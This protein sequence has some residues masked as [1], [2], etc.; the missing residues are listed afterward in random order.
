[1]LRAR[2]IRRESNFDS[3][4]EARNTAAPFQRKVPP[5]R[6]TDFAVSERFPR[7]SCEIVECSIPTDW[8]KARKE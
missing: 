3:S 5:M 2:A 8:A 6:R 4:P 1:M 7:N